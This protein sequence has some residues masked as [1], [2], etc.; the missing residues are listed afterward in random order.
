MLNSLI[1]RAN[2]T[3]A[4]Q[5]RHAFFAALMALGAVLP[6]AGRVSAAP[7]G[8][9]P[10]WSDE[11]EGTTLDAE[12]WDPIL[13]LTPYNNEKQAYHPS[14]ATVADGNLI[15]TADKTALGSKEYTSAKVESKY[16]QQ[17]GRWEV[18]AKLPSTIGTWPAIWLL[19]DTD[20][21]SWPSQGE[22]DIMENRGNQPQITS[23]AFHYGPNVA[24][25]QYQ[26][27]EQRAG[28]GGQPVNYHDDFHVY[29]VEWDANRLR[30]FVD[31]V[32][33]LTVH[34]ADVSG[35][36]GNQ[37]A[38][39]ETVLNVAVGGDFLG[40]AQPNGSSVWPQQMLVDY[41]RI[42]ERDANPPP[43]VFANAGFETNGGGLAGWSVFGNTLAA[44]PNVQVHNQATLEGDNALKLFGQ[45]NG[46]DNFS[47]VSQGITV[48]EGDHVE[49]GVSTFIRSQDSIA[50]TA[51]Q[52]FLKIEF[53]SE[54]GGQYGTAEML[55]ESIELIADGASDEDQWIAHDLS[56]VAPA[57]AVEARIVLVLRQPGQ[58]GGAVHFDGVSFRNL[59][60]PMPADADGDGD[61]D[62]QDF[63]EWQRGHGAAEPAANTSGDFNFDGQVNGSDLALWQQQFGAPAPNASSAGVMVAEPSGVALAV[64]ALLSI[65][66]TRALTTRHATNNADP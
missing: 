17:Y 44:T 32:H 66:E 61:V 12:K 35:F 27:L 29:A 49:A 18:R 23:S 48:A 53:Y 41:V 62:G 19:P 60:L 22:I 31:D 42:F 38:S 21:Y 16:T 52:A 57:G 2:N 64:V 54:F 37:T 33:F 24:G 43:T 51:N 3:L 50:G 65:Y 10:T 28:V 45:F 11:F 55:G 20:V 56:A 39:M 59:D 26:S 7:A 13:W 4:A 36:L 25:H 58:E 30:F 9:N 47:G 46:Q 5:V 6:T 14:R 34:D 15:L 8:W 40:G 1:T 63:L